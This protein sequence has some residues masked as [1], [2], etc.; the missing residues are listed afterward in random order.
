MTTD[1]PQ[2]KST[3]A[4]QQL[5]EQSA[6]SSVDNS[7]QVEIKLWQGGFSAKAM[8]GTWLLWIAV[9]LIG[10]TALVSMGSHYQLAWPIGGSL[11]I[12]GWCYAIAMYLYRRLA[13]HYEL[14]N[15]RFIHQQGI[16]IRNTNRIELID[17]DDVGITQ[18]IIQRMLG[19][20]TIKLT[21][22]DSTHPEFYLCGIDQVQKVANQIDDAR[23]AERRRRSVHIEAI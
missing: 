17:I 2:S 12:L 13:V 4:F 15:Q 6:N 16:L 5:A 1:S 3:K 18:G 20:G 10:L 14:T 23:R 19:V 11:I 22:S 21:G 9:T 8:Y 7:Q